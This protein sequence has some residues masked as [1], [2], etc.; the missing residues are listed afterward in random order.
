VGL[1]LRQT[2]AERCRE[3]RR[4]LAT[5]AHTPHPN[6]HPNPNP[7]QAMAL[8]EA[9]ARRVEQHGG[10]ALIIDY[11]QVAQACPLGAGCARLALRVGPDSQRL[12]ALLPWR[13]LATLGGVVQG[14]AC[15]ALLPLSP[16]L[17]IL[18]SYSACPPP[19]PPPTQY[20]PQDAPYESSL[21]AIR[22][23]AFVPLL[24]APGIA[25]ISNRVDFSALRW[26]RVARWRECVRTGRSVSCHSFCWVFVRV[27][28][29]CCRC[30]RMLGA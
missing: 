22:R 2:H 3:A 14:P 25:D 4:S 19:P 17:H 20:T 15:T 5:H 10:A 18:A 6:P 16:L 24:Q 23:H 21:Q 9:L 7:S 30:C 28:R 11:G 1:L 12:P 26:G 8:A 27:R 29:C 13:A